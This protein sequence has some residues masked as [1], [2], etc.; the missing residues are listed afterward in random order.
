[1]SLGS[2]LGPI[3]ENLV[4]AEFDE[5]AADSLIKDVLLQFHARFVDST[6]DLAKAKDTSE[7]L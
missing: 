7:S 5:V 6:L 2:S 4:L 3:L 1:M